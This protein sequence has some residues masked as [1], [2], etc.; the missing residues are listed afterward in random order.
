MSRQGLVIVYTGDGK[1]KTTAAL[2]MALRAVGYNFKSI[3]FQ[4]VKG[5][6][7]SGELAAMERLKPEFEIRPCGKGFIGIAGDKLLVEE[8]Q[9]AAIQALDEV[10]R[11]ISKGSYDIVILD[12]IFIALGLGLITE[13]QVLELLDARPEPLHLVLTG[14]GCPASIIE[15][16]DVVTEMNEIKHPYQQGRIAEIGVDF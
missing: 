3:M 6:W 13:E 10:R 8:H 4:F 1:G 16:A 15:R 5:G 12:E 9:K 11:V 7:R 14:R 2:G